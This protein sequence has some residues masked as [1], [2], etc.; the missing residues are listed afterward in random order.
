MRAS[1]E[2]SSHGAEAAYLLKIAWRT[3]PR[4]G[5]AALLYLLVGLYLIFPV[6]DR[7]QGLWEERHSPREITASVPEGPVALDEL[8][9]IEGIVGAS[10]L[11]R[12]EAEMISGG[13]SLTCEVRA[14]QRGYLRLSFTEGTL[15]PEHSN[16]PVLV[17][18]EAAAQILGRGEVT[19]HQEAGRRTSQICGVFAD[20]GTEPAAYMSYETAAAVFPQSACRELLLTLSG[21]YIRESAAAELLGLGVLPEAEAGDEATRETMVREISCGAMLSL[22]CLLCVGVIL[23]ERHRQELAARMEEFAALRLA[24]M[25][26]PC[27][28]VPLRT[29]FT[30]MCCT[31]GAAAAALAADVF[32]WPA[33]G[34][35]VCCIPFLCGAQME[36]RNSNKS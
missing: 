17:V 35:C 32:S 26:R 34:I 2:Q 8:L 20:G 36:I 13:Q 27:A 1:S 23:R 3:I 22:G 28:M 9:Q 25:R 31:I 16:M 12:M 6:C 11:R 24:G 5:A 29:G 7:A 30:A 4:C 15:F 14:V 19:L 33:L 18:N 21:K 10:P